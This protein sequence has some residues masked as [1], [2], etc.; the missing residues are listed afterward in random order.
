MVWHYTLLSQSETIYQHWEW[1]RLLHH[2]LIIRVQIFAAIC[3]RYYFQSI[4]SDVW[5]NCA[6]SCQD[7]PKFQSYD[8]RILTINEVSIASTLQMVINFKTVFQ[9]HS[10]RPKLL[11][12]IIVWFGRH[13]NKMIS[14]WPNHPSEYFDSFLSWAD[15]KAPPTNY[16]DRVYKREDYEIIF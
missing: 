14:V 10:T 7:K 3:E 5:Y 9:H 11:R 12:P 16:D 1:S 2:I 4:I 15:V 8:L 6:Q 13:E